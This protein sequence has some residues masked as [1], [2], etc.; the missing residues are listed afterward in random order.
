[1]QETKSR[2]VLSIIYV[3]DMT[4]SVYLDGIDL[5][6][7]RLSQCR[8]DSAVLAVWRRHVPSMST[9]LIKVAHVLREA[10]THGE[11]DHRRESPGRGQ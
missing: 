6:L 10:A 4:A 2:F 7:Q 1:M 5:L 11:P 8:F 3:L 9:N